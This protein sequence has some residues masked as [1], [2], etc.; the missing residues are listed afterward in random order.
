MSSFETQRDGSIFVTRDDGATLTIPPGK[1]S[2]QDAAA[3]AFVGPEAPPKK[4]LEDILLAKGVLTP[5]DISSLKGDTTSA[6]LGV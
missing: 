3:Q 4:T 6:V 2:V 5:Q 1:Q